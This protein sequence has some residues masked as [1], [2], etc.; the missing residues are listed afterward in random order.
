M[1]PPPAPMRPPYYR[2]ASRTVGARGRPEPAQA[3][4]GRRAGLPAGLGPGPGPG[5]LGDPRLQV[6]RARHC[7]SGRHRQPV[8]GHLCKSNLPSPRH[9]QDH[10]RN[11]I[12][13]ISES[14]EPFHPNPYARRTMRVR[15]V[16][17]QSHD[18]SHFIR[19]GVMERFPSNEVRLPVQARGPCSPSPSPLAPPRLPPES[20]PPAGPTEHV[21]ASQSTRLFPTPARDDHR[22]DSVPLGQKFGPYVPNLQ[23]SISITL[24]ANFEFP[25]KP[26]PSLP[27]KWPAL[28]ALPEQLLH[29]A[30]RGR[31]GHR[32][33]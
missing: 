32:R 19:L 30:S 4:L 17:L 27:R 23:S 10:S 13:V 1:R 14:S 22:I 5:Y 11:V 15:A 16:F 8:P 20:L 28:H 6:K 25:K 7:G 2:T 21:I 24:F 33:A 12:R 31:S 26:G 29:H 18:S 9:I 3:R